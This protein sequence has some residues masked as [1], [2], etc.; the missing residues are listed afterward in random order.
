ML[1]E[2]LLEHI[3]EVAPPLTLS[4]ITSWSTEVA[5]LDVS[6]DLLAA[7][8]DDELLPTPLVVPNAESQRNLFPLAVAAAVALIVIIALGFVGSTADDG[9]VATENGEGSAN[10]EL[11]DETEI[12]GG[13]LAAL[14]MFSDDQSWLVI[15]D[16]FVSPNNG[17]RTHVADVVVAD[18]VV[19]AVGSEQ[20]SEG[21]PLVGPPIVVQPTMWRSDDG[22]NWDAVDFGADPPPEVSSDVINVRAFEKV[23]TTEDGAIWAFGN[24]TTIGNSTTDLSLI[25]I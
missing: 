4:D 22:Q 2:R 7:T 11:T 18:G 12:D 13:E 23:I 24:S 8:E 15:E 17:F 6:Q 25:H 9:P 20:L 10:E 19:W 5:P 16:P 1:S 21:D 3:D 14:P